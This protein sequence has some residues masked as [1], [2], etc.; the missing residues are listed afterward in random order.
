MKKT[1]VVAIS[2]LVVNFL[3]A[4]EKAEISNQVVSLSAPLNQLGNNEIRFNLA[5]AIAG[6]PELNFERFVSDNA[7]FGLTIAASLEKPESMITRSMFLPYG[8]LYFGEKKDA[9]FFIEANMA[10]IGQ[11]DK[12]NEIIFD[13]ATNTYSGQRTI[14]NKA[15][16]FGFGCAAGAKFLARNGYIGEVIV[17]GGR[18][19]G[20]NLIGGYPRFGFSVGKRF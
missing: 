18:L 13:T 15:V 17:G 20:N 4:Q 11:R 10:I 12:Y 3:Y 1:F 19:F 5:T 16:S 6:L 8:R 14:D 7:S 2:F 9:G